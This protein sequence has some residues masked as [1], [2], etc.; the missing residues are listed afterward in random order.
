M[1]AITRRLAFQLKSVLRR[2][3]GAGRS[4]GPVLHFTAAAEGL[5]VRAKFADTAIEYRTAVASGEGTL[6]LPFDFLADY[7]ATMTTTAR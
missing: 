4:Y 2:A 6:W 7:P 3:F 1:I 5:R